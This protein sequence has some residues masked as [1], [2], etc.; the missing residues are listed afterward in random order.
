MSARHGVLPRGLTSTV[1]SRLHEGFFGRMFRFLDPATFGADDRQTED[2]LTKLA[3]AMVVLH[4]GCETSGC[5]V[6]AA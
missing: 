3:N 1:R 4:H 5:I 6:H 2:N